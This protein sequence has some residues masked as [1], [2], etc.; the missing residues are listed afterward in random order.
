M[1]HSVVACYILLQ[2]VAACC[3]V[4]QRVASYCSVL[5]RGEVVRYGCVAVYSNLLQCV[6]QCALRC[7][8][9]LSGPI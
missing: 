4:L 1:L 5:Q 8:R 3:S 7:V 6:L 9:P 2:R